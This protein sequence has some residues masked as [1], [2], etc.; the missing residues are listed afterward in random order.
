MGF[1]STRQNTPD[2]IECYLIDS[3]SHGEHLLRVAANIL[4][5]SNTHILSGLKGTLARGMFR[6]GKA[7]TTTPRHTKGLSPGVWLTQG[8]HPYPP[9]QRSSVPA[10]HRVSATSSRT[11]LGE[12][13]YMTSESSLCTNGVLLPNTQVQRVSLQ[14]QEVLPPHPNIFGA[15]QRQA[16]QSTKTLINSFIHFRIFK[17]LALLLYNY[18]MYISGHPYQTYRYLSL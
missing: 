3:V 5:Q 18:I 13:T 7:P 14:T 11:G 2:W 15:L 1:G 16:A 8:K 12:I 6:P 9:H 17:L 10:A 4:H